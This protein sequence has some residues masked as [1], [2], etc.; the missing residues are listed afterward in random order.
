MENLNKPIS[1]AIKDF[2][3]RKIAIKYMRPEEDIHKI[4]MNS[5]EEANKATASANEVEIS[6][7]GKFMFSENKAKK[8]YRKMLLCINKYN[9]DL[10]NTQP[11][12][13]KNQNKLLKKIASAQEVINFI[14]TRIDVE[15]IPNP[16]GVE[17][18]LDTTQGS[19]GNDS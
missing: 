11:G 17:K 5:F 4:I 3:I 8:I 19:E 1:L 18:S 15:H 7:F 10:A 13:S 9:R 2:L 6:G 14:K 12:D 16:R